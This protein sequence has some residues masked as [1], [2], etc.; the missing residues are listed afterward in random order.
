MI[1]FLR[2]AVH[3]DAVEPADEVAAKG[4]LRPFERVAL[5]Y[6]LDGGTVQNLLRLAAER[7]PRLVQRCRI[8][9]AARPARS[10]V[11]YLRGQHRTAA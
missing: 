8:A 5:A 3:P 6:A 2:A 9:R 1:D 10:Q 4:G 7:W 11:A